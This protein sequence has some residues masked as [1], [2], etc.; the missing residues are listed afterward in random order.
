MSQSISASRARIAPSC[1]EGRPDLVPLLVAV[2][3]GGQVL[4]PVLGPAHRAAQPQRGGGH[5]HLLPA[6]H[7]LEAE[8]SA[9]VRGD[10]PDLPLRQAERLRDPGPDLVRDLGGDVHDQLVVAVVPLGQ[11]GAS[12]QR[13]RGDPRAGERGAHGQ[14]RLGE[15]GGE[16]VVVEHQQVDQAVALGLLVQPGRGRG[17][18]LLDAG[19]RGQR[20][21]VHLDQLDRVLGPVGIVGDHHRHRLADEPDRLAGQDGHPGGHELLP[22]QHREQVGVAEAGGGDD[23]DHAVGLERGAGVDGAEAGVGVRAADERGVQQA[24]PGLGSRSAV[25]RPRPSSIRR[26]SFRGIAAPTHWLTCDP[27]CVH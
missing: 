8:P 1:V 5:G 10:H 25:K 16:P 14:R 3:R 20:S 23:V 11:A 26:S 24:G 19:H 4:L 6:D 9:D 18:G 27:G 7:A 17:F 22:L 12:L 13:Q 15:D 2:E 21:P